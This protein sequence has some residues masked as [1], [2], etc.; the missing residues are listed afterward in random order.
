MIFYQDRVLQ[1][2]EP[3]REV[4]QRQEPGLHEPRA[5]DGGPQPRCQLLYRPCHT[6]PPVR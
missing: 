4:Q 1:A 5:A 3:E 2:V 6:V